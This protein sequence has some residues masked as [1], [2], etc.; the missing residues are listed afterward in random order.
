MRM[1]KVLTGGYSS[2][3]KFWR[4][5]HFYAKRANGSLALRGQHRRRAYSFRSEPWELNVVYYEAL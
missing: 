4:L 2:G 5:P 3:V 1:V